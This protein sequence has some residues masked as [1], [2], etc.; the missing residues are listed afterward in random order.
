MKLIRS[1]VTAAALA[2]AVTTAQANDIHFLKKSGS[3]TA[4]SHISTE[5]VPMV[6]LTF[7]GEGRK[8]N[9]YM[10]YFGNDQLIVHLYKPGWQFPKDGVDVSFQVDFDHGGLKLSYPLTGRG[11]ADAAGGAHIEAIL[12]DASQ[13][14][15]F[16]AN[17][18][19]AKQMTIVFEQGNE[20]PWPINMTGSRAT[21]TV[22]AAAMITLPKATPKSDDCGNKGDDVT[23]GTPAP[24]LP[25]ELRASACAKL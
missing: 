15:S 20:R 9:L 14:S 2:L 23:T 7:Q 18:I 4:Y 16:I 12:D 13:M 8:A 3:W 24:P 6:G 17:T 25:S 1:L 19:N 10:K 22:F 11:Q 5:G 21:G